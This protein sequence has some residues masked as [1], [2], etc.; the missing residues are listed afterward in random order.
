MKLNK[1]YQ[2]ELKHHYLFKDFSEEALNPVFDHSYIG[3]LEKN[4][5]LFV[6]GELAKNF[7]M[8]RTG[9]IMLYQ[10]SPAGDEK[11]IEIIEPGNTFAEAVMF[12]DHHKYPINA[13][14]FSKTEL[15]YIDNNKFIEQLQKSPELCFKLMAG[16]SMR[17]RQMINDISQLTIYNAQHR[18]ISY[19]LGKLNE[20]QI[21]DNINPS[22][23]L[24]VSKIMLS[25]RL[26]ITP[27]TFSRTLLKLKK[28]GLIKVNKDTVTLIRPDK[29][30]QLIG[31]NL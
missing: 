27:E 20:N 5:V 25:S 29:L 26:S 24:S 17:L 13:R 19:L 16:M 31:D 9:K 14:A 18:I 28:D 11:I 7:Y 4:E 10:L 15:F 8:V 2:N 12:M 30:K 23:Q 6:S 1:L 22:V 21:K 3:T